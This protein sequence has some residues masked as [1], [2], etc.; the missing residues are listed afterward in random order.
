MEKKAFVVLLGSM[1]VSML[2]MNIIS[3]LLPVYAVK[4]GASSFEIGLVQAAFSLSGMSTLLFIGRL[5]DRLGRKLFLVGGLVILA[6]SSI[7]LMFAGNS[8]HLILLR[9]VQ[10]FGAST[11]LAI[12]QAYMGD[13]IL[14]GS[15][16]KWVG[17]FNAVLFA[18]MGAGPL[19]GGVIADAFSISTAFLVLAVL[20]I[21][22]LISVLTFL[23]EKPRK[24]AAREHT[25]YVAPLKSPIMR[26]VISYRM[27]IGICTATLM[28]FVPLLAG[29]RIGLSASLIG[30]MMAARIPISITQSYTGRLSDKRD[31]R[32]MVIWS[33]II[34]V[35]TVSLMPA[36]RGF[37][38]LLIAYLLVTVGQA[39]GLPA[40]NAY[41]VSE[42]RIYGMGASVTMF[43][44]AMYA[45]NSIGPVVLG[46]IADRLGLESAFYAAAIC[47]ATG[48]AL[49]AGM[50]RNPSTNAAESPAWK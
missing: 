46:G 47:M 9:F 2:G 28:A 6:A 35:A 5:S 32:S 48:T 7:G 49:F 21:F 31:R 13:S 40:A 41:V 39:V 24:V 15:E 10:G 43:M 16:G 33:G 4:M 45:G 17:G 37:W 22:G 30:I 26:G 29:L 44:M 25:S 3:P 11:Y 19:I 23:K 27:A 20:N 34:C 50:I 38:T 36:A 42:G 1:F 8:V 12:A 14:A 18:G